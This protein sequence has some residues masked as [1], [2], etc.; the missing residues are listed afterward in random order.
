MEKL[1]L[2]LFVALLI[3]VLTLVKKKY[4]ETYTK[5]AFPSKVL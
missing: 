3:F 2:L 1:L 4:P 5:Y